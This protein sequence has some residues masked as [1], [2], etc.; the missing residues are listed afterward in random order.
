MR[1]KGFSLVELLTVLSIL[2][3]LASVGLVLFTNVQTKGRD[4]TR[5]QDLRA[6]AQ[7]L[8]IYFQ[9]F[10]QYIPPESGSDSCTRDTATFYTNIASYMANQ[11]A[12]LDPLTGTE[13]CYLS[14]NNGQSFRLF[15]KFED[16]NDGDINIS[17][18]SNQNYNYTLTSQ[19]LL[20]ICAP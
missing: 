14:V 8:E 4:S 16:T 10:D 15:T 5:K 9:K 12:P 20:P 7:A 17:A 3:I 11:R 2:A 13:Y 1:S 19:D 6:F 18:C